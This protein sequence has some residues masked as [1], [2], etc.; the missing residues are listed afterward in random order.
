M[1]QKQPPAKV[2]KAR[3]SGGSEGANGWPV[4]FASGSV[5]AQAATEKESRTTARN[6]DPKARDA[7]DMNP[8]ENC[9]TALALFDTDAPRQL[10]IFR[11]DLRLKP[12]SG[13]SGQQYLLTSLE[14]RGWRGM[15]M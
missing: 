13:L 8:P 10:S 1:H 11:L 7:C 5:S 2:A 6:V 4:F 12:E 3:F 15:K 14:T 9:D